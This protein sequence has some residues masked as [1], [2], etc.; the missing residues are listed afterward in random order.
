MSHIT[1][2]IYG[3]IY[4]TSGG[5]YYDRQLIRALEKK[6]HTV[7]VADLLK[8]EK[9]DDNPDLYIIDELCHPDIYR[10]S[11]FKRLES[12]IP[13]AGMVHHLAVDENLQ[14]INKMVHLYKERRFFSFLNFAIFNSLAT[15]ESSFK[16]GRF[17]G[18]SEIAVPGREDEKAIEPEQKHSNSHLSLLFIGNLIPR[19]G[20]H[21]VIHHL[22]EATRIPY[23]FIIAGDDT[24]DPDYAKMIKDLIR[25][26]N[27]GGKIKIKGSISETEKN[28]LL[29][30]SEILLMPSSHEGYGIVYI[31]AMRYGVIPV[32]GN[33]GGASEIISNRKNGYM[34]DPESSGELIGILTQL[35]ENPALKQDISRN[36]FTTWKNHTVWDQSFKGVIDELENLIL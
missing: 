27:L 33:S 22:A 20:M 12:G 17:K 5:Y 13:I 2:L 23:E 11:Q 7:M 4:Q 36:A 31:E 14:F 8:Y 10:R 29:E 15:R 30:K 28:K 34:V 26:N 9:R 16:K 24:V 21:H 3:D 19:K 6:G 25:Q 35:W 32:A 18:A 1:F